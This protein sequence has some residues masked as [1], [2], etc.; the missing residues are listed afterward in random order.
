MEL[1]KNGDITDCYNLI[2]VYVVISYHVS[3]LCKWVT[4]TIIQQAVDEEMRKNEQ[5]QRCGAV[6]R[7]AVNFI[8]LNIIDFKNPLAAFTDQLRGNPT[9]QWH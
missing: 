8:Y 4:L 9:T 5:E 2:W 6:H 1:L 7:M 3:R